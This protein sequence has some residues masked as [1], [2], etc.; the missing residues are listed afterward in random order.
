MSTVEQAVRIETGNYNVDTVHSQV[1]CS[2]YR[3]D[4]AVVDPDAPGRYLLGVE[5]DGR[6]YHSAKT[7]RDRDRLRE[8]VLNELGWS[9]V[10]VWSTDW[11]EDP[12]G[13]LERRIRHSIEP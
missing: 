5:C 8:A 11:W 6:N 2:D 3:I 9:I 1:G 13:Q 10:R 12:V 4:L 7:A